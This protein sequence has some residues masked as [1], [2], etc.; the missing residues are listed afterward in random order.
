MKDEMTDIEKLQKFWIDQYKEKLPTFK[1]FS[2]TMKIYKPKYKWQ[3]ILPFWVLKL[4]VKPT[5]FY[6]CFPT[7]IESIVNTNNEFAYSVTFSYKDVK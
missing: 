4:F 2:K 6:N 5:S 1:E 7:Q 3:K